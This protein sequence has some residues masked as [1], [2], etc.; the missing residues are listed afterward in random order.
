MSHTSASNSGHGKFSGS[1]AAFFSWLVAPWF[2]AA[3]KTHDLLGVLSHTPSN[4]LL[5]CWFWGAMWGLGG[6]TF[7]LT[8][9]YL[10]LSLGMAIALG[11][12]TAIGTM[13]P[14]IFHGTL[15][16]L[17]GSLGGRLTFFGIAIAYLKMCAKISMPFYQ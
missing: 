6:L 11:L 9:R 16:S 2:L 17:A 14:P 8:M 12:T 1:R 3:I 7:G 15:G 10:G 5:W 4:T 13:G